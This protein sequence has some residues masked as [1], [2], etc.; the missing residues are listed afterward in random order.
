MTIPF[1]KKQILIVVIAAAAVVTGVI[2]FLATRGGADAE[3]ISQGR[4]YLAQMEQG[5]PSAVDDRLAQIEE[6]KVQANLDALRQSLLDDPEQV[7]SQFTDFV[8]IGDSRAEGFD[9]YEFLP[10]DRVLATK[11]LLI[12]YLYSDEVRIALQTLQPTKIWLVFG[13][14]D[15][16]DSQNPG[17]LDNWVS[18]YRDAVV[19]IRNLLPNAT[20]FV[21][22]I[23]PVIEPASA[24]PCYNAI[25][26]VNEALA[27]MCA[28]TG[29]VFEDA[30]PQLEGHPEYYEPDG[31]HFTYDFYPVWATDMLMKYYDVVGSPGTVPGLNAAGGSATDTAAGTAAQ[32][33]NAAG[34]TGADGTAGADTAGAG[35]GTSDGN[36]YGEDGSYAE[37]PYGTEQTDPAQEESAPTVVYWDD[38]AQLFYYWDEG[39]QEYLYLDEALQ[40]SVYWDDASGQYLVWTG[41]SW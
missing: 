18:N 39:A 32:S 3:A 23:L 33:E 40:G 36:D 14:N 25:P 7:W 22:S 1:S 35:D 31:M 10:M 30:T 11:G 19:E 38:Y 29:A 12:S 41:Q 28:Q 5:D 21:C 16:G 9:A 26:D 17:W 20:V 13:N 37:D 24:D 2:I 8:I 34:G 4:E 15:I 6:E 27:G